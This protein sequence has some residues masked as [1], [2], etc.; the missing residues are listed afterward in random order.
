MHNFVDDNILS[1]WRERV[2]KVIDI[3]GSEGN[4]IID[5]F[6]KNEMIINLD[7]FQ[8]IIMIERYPILQ[9]SRGLLIIKLLSQ[10]HQ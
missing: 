4:I 6:T 7:T 2:S 5:S 9:T 8:A 3:L 1:A 10:L